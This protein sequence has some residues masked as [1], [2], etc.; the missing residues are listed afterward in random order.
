MTSMPLTSHFP[1]ST[2]IP[3]RS[4]VARLCASR[5]AQF[6]VILA[7]AVAFRFPAYGEWNYAIDDQYYA[8]VGHRLL[9]GDLLYV[10][11]WD[12]KGPALY[13]TF[14]LIGLISRSAIAY[15]L[16]ATLVA[17]MGG[18]GVNR[19]ARRLA[20]AQ[21]A[22]LSGVVYIALLNRFEGDNAEAGVFFNTWLIAAAALIVSRLNRLRRGHIDRAVVAAFACAGIA[23][24][25]KQSAAIE[26]ACFGLFVIVM[27][28][29]GGCKPL[30]VLWK[31]AP[32]ALAGAL[33]M[34]LT[35]LFYLARGHFPEMWTAL[36]ESNLARGYA[37]PGIRFKGQLVMIGMLGIPLV[38]GGI[39]L[40]RFVTEARTC[41]EPQR[42][43]VLAFVCLWLAA[44]LFGLATFP[45]IYVHYA[46]STLAPFA[47]LCAGYFID[48]R[49]PWLGIGA[50][51][52]V[53]L[54]LSG[55]FHLKDRWRARPAAR[56]MVD[57]IL[58]QTPR[59]DIF[60]WGNPNFLYAV[61]GTRPPSVLAFAPHMYEGREWTGID[62]VA[63][64]RQVLAGRPSTVISQFPIQAAP[65]NMTN[66]RQVED[67]VRAC[68]RQRKF[69]IYD[70]NGP[71]VQT[72][73]SGCGR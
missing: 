31:A 30:S 19:I 63:A 12:R 7:L 15:Q 2:T 41:G 73:F 58:E 45:N 1:R 29:R 40:H 47:I 36:V 6:L 27:L 14:S 17:A 51:I 55:T 62:E 28:L 5:T 54:A 50:L 3:A 59:R 49:S 61:V 56:E 25:Y 11:I 53:S 26:G 70:H 33:P 39:G 37:D 8:L 64:L 4:L 66:V 32:L 22:L 69:T 13:L 9:D 38:F 35:G 18:Y 43:E 21:W 44:A 52:G 42:R 68:K 16:A 72:V 34:L 71:Q 20:P 57:Y 24:A 48:R 67:Y 65:L 10:D 60:V 23:I 46:Q